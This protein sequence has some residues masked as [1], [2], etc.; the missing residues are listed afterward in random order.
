[1]TNLPAILDAGSRPIL[2]PVVV[3]KPT[4]SVKLITLPRFDPAHRVEMTLAY[5]STLATLV[6]E[7]LPALSPERRLSMVRVTIGGHMIEP[8]F[9]HVVRPKPGTL[10]VI[11]VV[12]GKGS[13]LRSVLLITASIAAAALGQFYL[14]PELAAISITGVAATAITG[15]ATSVLAQGDTIAVNVLQPCLNIA[16]ASFSRHGLS[17]TATGR[18]GSSVHS[19]HDPG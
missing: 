13:I 11:R 1:M 17:L 3:D 14:A 7:Q 19:D 18:D 4:A 12:P 6:K 9:W 10:V 2:L 15:A 8:Q 16:R 5:G